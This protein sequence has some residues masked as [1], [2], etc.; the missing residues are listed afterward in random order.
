MPSRLL[1]AVGQI[2]LLLTAGTGVAA[3]LD[4]SEGRI[5]IR[6]RAMLAMAACS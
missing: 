2:A 1:G 4:R 6:G 3:L 5:G